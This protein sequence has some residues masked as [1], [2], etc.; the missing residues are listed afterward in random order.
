LNDNATPLAERLQAELADARHEIARLKAII[1]N[2]EN[3]NRLLRAA[4][5]TLG[6]PW[7]DR[8]G[9]RE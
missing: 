6:R 9:E 8:E 4:N 2:L 1:E 5:A 3:D 7:Q